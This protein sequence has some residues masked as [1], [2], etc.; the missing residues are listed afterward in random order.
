MAGNLPHSLKIRQKE[1]C[2][3]PKLICLSGKI[4]NR[5]SLERAQ[6]IGS[7]SAKTSFELPTHEYDDQS[8]TEQ[9]MVA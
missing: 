8:S 9:E 5:G 7:Y 4:S 1:G 3:L 6:K 2:Q